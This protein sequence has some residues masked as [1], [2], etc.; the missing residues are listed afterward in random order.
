MSKRVILVAASLFTLTTMYGQKKD[1]TKILDEV[2]ITANKMPQKQ[3]TTGKVVTVINKEQIEKSSGKTVA[4]LL[5]EQAGVT[6]NGALNN[7]GANQTV[8][9]RGASSGRVLILV[10]GVPA[11]DPS[12]IG[13]EFDLN[14]LSLNSVESIEIC[15]G[16]QSTLYGS[17]AI[18]GVINI[19]TVNKDVK[20]PFNVKATLAAGNY[21]TFRGNI[22]VYGKAD[23]LTYSARYG[24]LSSTGFSSAHDSTGKGDFDND[25]LTSDI[26]NAS[27]QYQVISA[28]SLRSFIQYSQYKTD[29]DASTFTD[30]KDFNV[31]NKNLMTGFGM[32]FQKNNVS[33]TGNYQYSENKRNYVNPTYTDDYFG[34][35][36]FAELY[37]SI[38]ICKH[39][40]ILQGGDH[41]YSSMHSVYVGSFGTYP[42]ADTA[43][44]QSSLYSSLLFHALKER[45]NIEL[46]GRL[47]VHSRY[48]S[49]Y[50]YTFNPSFAIDNHFR[51]FGSISTG[52]KAPT[53]YQ[54]F[55][56]SGN[57]NLKPESSKTYEGGIQ[58]SCKHVSGRVVYFNRDIK[59]VIDFDNINYQYFNINRQRVDGI[60]VEAKTAPYKG[61]SITANYTYLNPKENSQSRTSYNDSAYR[62]LLRRA[63]NNFNVNVGYQCCKAF[64]ISVSGKYVGRRYDFGGYD[65][66]YN[67]KA[68]VKLDHYFLLGAY[69]EY[70][71]KKYVKLF[72]DAQNITDKKFF[73]VNGY[74]SIPFLINGGVTFNW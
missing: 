74:N 14:L 33:L 30:A 5:N 12:F 46:G 56:S 31:N 32:H 19:I 44:S 54:L 34:F 15:R 66:F 45:I 21:G 38:E 57:T 52:F 23:K 28:L 13:S 17:D 60:E 11:Y 29:L 69:A 65:A 18:A 73:D 24:R 58:A 20:K 9:M 35:S 6:I 63:A 50:T 36:Q 61:I 64:Y 22:Q 47:N 67:P 49:N 48:G 70:K 53:L 68:D 41:R 42:F 72:A 40:T 26:V 2:M 7:L 37:S 55:S 25:G 27:L 3:S 62:Y 16:A 43:H 71:F 10:D 4:Q 8:Y 1:T 59:N 39:L 51:L